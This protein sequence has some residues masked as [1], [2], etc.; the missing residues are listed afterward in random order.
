M[1]GSFLENGERVVRT[2]EMMGWLP[3]ERSGA[4]NARSSEDGERRGPP[5]ELDPSK[6]AIGG[7]TCVDVYWL[8]AIRMAVG[9]DRFG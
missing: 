9:D 2:T 4:P 7:S 6:L 1:V 5:C 8:A 3:K